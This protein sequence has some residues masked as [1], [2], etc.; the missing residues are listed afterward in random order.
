MKELFHSIPKRKE[1][2]KKM[3]L[4]QSDQSLL[5][6]EKY[7]MKSFAS[8]DSK[9]QRELQILSSDLVNPLPLP[10]LDG[11][12]AKLELRHA[13]SSP[14]DSCSADRSAFLQKGCC[15]RQVECGRRRRSALEAGPSVGIDGGGVRLVAFWYCSWVKS[16]AAASSGAGGGGSGEY[17]V[18]MGGMI[19]VRLLELRRPGR[20]W[21]G[22]RR[23]HR[24]AVGDAEGREGGEV[25]EKRKEMRGIDGWSIV[26]L[27]PGRTGEGRGSWA[28]KVGR[29]RTGEGGG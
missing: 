9:T 19:P 1:E 5:R 29:H 17:R 21:G 16:M 22:E 27:M 23:G 12:A 2:Q 20:S 11:L 28:G 10:W 15:F 18:I 26:I 4:E 24:S 3:I 8:I 13:A 14:F 6:S 25:S 7:I